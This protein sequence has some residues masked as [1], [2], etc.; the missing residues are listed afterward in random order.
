LQRRKARSLKLKVV[1]YYLIDQV[2]YWKD[3]L[4]VLL[5]CMSPQEAEMIVAE[6]HSGLCGG[7]HFW[8]ATAHKI[9]KAGY[10][11][12]TVFTDVCKRVRACIKCQKFLGSQQLRS[13]SL[14]L[15]VVSGP[16]QQWG[17]DFIGEIH[18][19][20]S[21]QHRWILTT[22]DFF[23]KWIEA[24]PTRS[25]SHKV[26]I[27][28]LEDLITRFGCPNKIVTDNA[29]A[30]RSEPLAKLFEQFRIKLIH[31]TPYYPQGNGLVESSNKI[32]I[33]TI[34]RLL[35]DNKRAWNSKLK[36]ALWADRVTTKRA[37]GLSPFQLVYGAKYVFPS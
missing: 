9:L 22:I 4:G 30:F 32:L 8:K 16:F 35:E 18:P 2:L 15:V 11:W 29:V 20:S 13:L 28:F 5:K 26:I 19:A 31:S 34:K 21:G 33:R 25:A 6:F 23:T 37:I 1:R 24:I 10:Y 7:H 27:G 12:P 3:P 17:L 36:F 14:N